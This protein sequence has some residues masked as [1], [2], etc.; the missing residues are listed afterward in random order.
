[1]MAKTPL[2]PGGCIECRNYNWT[3]RARYFA[4]LVDK[5][6]NSRK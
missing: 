1:V 5:Q 6:F 2:R 4:K 3:G